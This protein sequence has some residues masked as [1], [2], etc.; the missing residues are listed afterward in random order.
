MSAIAENKTITDLII[1]AGQ[2]I[3]SDGFADV[4]ADARTALA[5]I[6]LPAPKTEEY[7]FIPIT[8]MLEKSFAAWPS[9]L[10]K[11]PVNEI[12]RYL[13]T[14]GETNLVVLING[15]FAAELSN[16]NDTKALVGPIQPNGLK[17]KDILFRQA[18]FSRDPFLAMNTMLWTAGVEI[19]VPDECVEQKPLIVLNIVDASEGPAAVHSRLVVQL[20]NN[21]GFSLIT[22]NVCLGA[23]ASFATM[24]EEVLVGEKSQFDYCRIQNE[25]LEFSFNHTAIRQLDKSHVNTFTLTLDGKL[26]RNNLNISIDGQNTE[27]HFHGLYLLNGD[28]IADNHTVVDHRKP[29]SFSNEMYK[30]VMDGKSK[31]VFNGK[32][33]VRP[34]AQKTNA[35]QSNRNILLSDQSSIN[36]KPQ[37]EIWADD[38]KCSH[39]CT[40]GQLDEEAM[41]YLRSRGIQKEKARAML[42]YAFAAETLGFIKNEPLKNYINALVMERLNKG[43]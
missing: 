2:Q 20:G 31:G 13:I 23:Q 35:F 1:E 10:P 26:I 25:K 4:R 6:K 32:I 5:E 24:V 22:R 38:V 36:T 41:F 14:G 8:R 39:G 17:T 30:G 34:D 3:A 16:L 19:V 43:Q 37:L 11:A 7:R 21:A 42:L 12:S 27:S 29:N 15:R 28:T 18:D 40:T 9:S 33:Y